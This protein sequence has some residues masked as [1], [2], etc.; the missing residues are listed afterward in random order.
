[1]RF[2]A[3]VADAALRL[4]VLFALGGGAGS[5]TPARRAFDRPMAIA[6]F[7]DRAPCFPSL[8]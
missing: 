1:L 4:V 8:T 3:R 2:A 5:F 6:C 7:V